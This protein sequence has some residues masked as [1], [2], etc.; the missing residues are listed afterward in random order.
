MLDKD[1][2]KKRTIKA[3]VVLYSIIVF[4]ILFGREPFDI[5]YS[6]LEHIKM[7][8]NITPF[9]TIATLCR[10]IINRTNPHLLKYSLAN[11]FGNIALFIPYGILVPILFT[12]YRKMWTYLIHA[13]IIIFVIEI[14]QFLSLRGSFDIDDFLLNLFGAMIGYLLFRVI[15]RWSKH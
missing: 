3:I 4:F 11:L 8:I 7:N 6:Y 13:A 1:R 14:V 10:Q 12:K 2:R 15:W 5:G 9:Y